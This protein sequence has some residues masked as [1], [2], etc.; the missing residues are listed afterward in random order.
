VADDDDDP[1]TIPE[2]LKLTQEQRRAAW[3][4]FK[5][6]DPRGG[7]VEEWRLRQEEARQ[8]RADE[9]KRKNAEALQ[10]LKDA[11]PDERYDRKKKQWVPKGD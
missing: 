6:T 5:H 10:R 9:K 11:H 2:F 7:T 1:W 8:R 4:G 3:V